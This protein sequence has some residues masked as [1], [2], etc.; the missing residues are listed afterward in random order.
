MDEEGDV[1]MFCWMYSCIGAM[2]DVCSSAYTRQ[3][4]CIL[5]DHQQIFRCSESASQ[6][7][8]RRRLI[9]LSFYPLQSVNIN[10]LTIAIMP[11][12]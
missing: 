3:G 7:S 8:R 5:K 10:V 1:T 9:N 11:R 4:L 12:P 2:L 6:K